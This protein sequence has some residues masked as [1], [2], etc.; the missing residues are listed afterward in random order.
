[1]EDKDFEKDEKRVPLVVVRRL[2]RYYRY[3]TDLKDMGIERVS[4]QV[5]S[6][7]L[8]FT[9]SQVRQD[10]N[11]F[12]GFGQQGYGYNVSILRD[13]ISKILGLERGYKIIIIGA[14]NLGHAILNYPGFTRRGFHFVG[15]FDNDPHC[16]GKAAGKLTI[17]AMEDLEEFCEKNRPD[18]AALAV[19]KEG[20][21]EIANKLEALGIKGF[22][23]FSHIEITSRLPVET[24]HLS[25]SLMTLSYKISLDEREDR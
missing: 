2:P 24:V 21:A 8:G 11:C 10:L 12:G 16:I 19:P 14:G 1:M 13:E 4:S 18:I 5:L 9:A 23:N 20:T 22:W 3:L 7:K 15:I 6:K 17:Q 25:D